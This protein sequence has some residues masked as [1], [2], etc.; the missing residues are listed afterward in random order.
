MTLSSL[1]C[2]EATGHPDMQLSSQDYKLGGTGGVAVRCLLGDLG[3]YDM[4]NV[5]QIVNLTEGRAVGI[6]ALI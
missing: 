4:Q 6:S 3:L 5:F 1:R 2:P